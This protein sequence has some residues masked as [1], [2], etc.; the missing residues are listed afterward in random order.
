MSGISSRNPITLLRIASAT[1]IWPIPTAPLEI[2]A[3]RKEAEISVI[4]AVSKVF[5]MIGICF[6]NAD[7]GQRLAGIGALNQLDLHGHTC[8]PLT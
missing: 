3:I 6:Q 7:L 1:V 4:R 8:K 2:P 5:E